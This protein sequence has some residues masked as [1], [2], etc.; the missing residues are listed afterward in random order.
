V[1][2]KF[3]KVNFY[4]S[5]NLKCAVS[6]LNS[7]HLQYF[8]TDFRHISSDINLLQK[9]KKKKKKSDTQHKLVQIYE[10]L[11]CSI[12]HPIQQLQLAD[13]LQPEGLILL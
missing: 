5:E 1:K 11:N 12:T 3:K 2:T 13:K 8:D 10:L 6:K 7:E 4:K 9:K